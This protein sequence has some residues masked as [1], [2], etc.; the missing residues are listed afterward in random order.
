MTRADNA[1]ESSAKFELSLSVRNFEFLSSSF[2]NLTQHCCNLDLPHTRRS[3]AAKQPPLPPAS[4]TTL[5]SYAS[6]R[7]PPL[8]RC[9]SC[10]CSAFVVIV[11]RRVQLMP[12]ASG[13]PTSASPPALLPLPVCNPFLAACLL[14][15]LQPTATLAAG[16]AARLQ[17]RLRWHCVASG[18]WRVAFSPDSGC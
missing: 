2:A 15:A 6:T 9:L 12:S 3:S 10:F 13:N 11:R 18:K 4:A 14:S 7:T 17:Q 1:S 16:S 8:S 5:C